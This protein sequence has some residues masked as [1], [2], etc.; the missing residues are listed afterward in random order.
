M[1]ENK[2]LARKIPENYISV[3]PKTSIIRDTIHELSF[4]RIPAT[5]INSSYSHKNNYFTINAGSNK[6]IKKKMGVISP[7]GVVGIVYDVSSHYAVVKSILTTSINISAF[8]EGSNAYGLIKYLEN[9]PRRVNLTG[10]SN[11]IKIKKGA[12]VF[13]RGSGGYFP[14]GAR[15]G[16][17]E[18]L[19][20]IEGK[21][22]WDITVRLSQDMRKLRYVYVVKNIFQEELNEL[23]DKVE[24]LE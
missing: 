6:G 10:V 1:N 2:E 3:D 15:I 22:M 16:T 20:P 13:A 8:V 21:P 23:Q 24:E 17:V 19:E 5:V 7:E 4:E 12:R 14:N 9:D 11:D 18:K